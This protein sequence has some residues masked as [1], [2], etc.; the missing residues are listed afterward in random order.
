LSAESTSACATCQ[1]HSRCG[2]AESKNKTLDIPTVDWQSYT[3]GDRVT[4][5]IDESR[6]MLA[7]WLAY[8]LPA[9]I[10]LAVIIALSVAGLPE[11]IVILATLAS[12]GLYILLLYLRRQKINTRFTLT[13]TH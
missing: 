1:A 10:M 13:L 2:F 7:V 11:W 3:Q 12:L 4:V 6:G 8:V 5:H 9:L